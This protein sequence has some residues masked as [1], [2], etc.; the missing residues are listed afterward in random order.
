MN[1]FNNIKLPRSAFA[2]GVYRRL[3]SSIPATLVDVYANDHI[4]ESVKPMPQLPHLVVSGSRG[5][6]LYGEDSVRFYSAL[7]D[8]TRTVFIAY[9]AELVSPPY[10]VSPLIVEQ[11]GAPGVDLTVR[12]VSQHLGYKEKTTPANWA[13]YDK[14]A[15]PI[16]NLEML[17][18]ADIFL[19]IWDGSSPGTADA[20]NQA[21]SRKIPGCIVVVD[22]DA[23]MNVV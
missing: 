12:L 15:G 1:K 23:M 2:A 6:K 4:G 9:T 13:A 17:S 7:Y 20:I 18:R 11:G 14:K 5:P 21:M 10:H 16:R 3:Q 22:F 19:A 8:V